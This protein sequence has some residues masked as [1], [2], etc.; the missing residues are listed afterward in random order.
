MLDE[1]GAS[2]AVF[3]GT[4]AVGPYFGGHADVGLVL[5]PED[6]EDASAVPELGEE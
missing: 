3:A 5:K 4:W 1:H 2:K 6:I